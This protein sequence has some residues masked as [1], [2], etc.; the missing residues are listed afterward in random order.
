MKKGVRGIFLYRTDVDLAQV[1]TKSILLVEKEQNVDTVKIGLVGTGGIGN[2]HA[3]T[4]EL[5]SFPF[6]FC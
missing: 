4:Y 5:F 1:Q 2:H 6:T 3:K